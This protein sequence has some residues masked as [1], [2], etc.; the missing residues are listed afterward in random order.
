MS[1]RHS[2]QA[3]YRTF[4]S[5]APDSEGGTNDGIPRIPACFSRSA[6]ICSTDAVS[7]HSPWQPGHSR[8]L[9]VPRTTGFI[10]VRQRGQGSGLFSSTSFLSSFA[11]QCEQNLEPTKVI[12]KQAGQATVARRA[13][14]CSQRVASLEA[15]APHMGQFNVSADMI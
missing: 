12:P 9:V 11:P 3:K 2:G 13:P 10:S 15:E 14:Q 8:K 5:I 4:S 7:A 6:Q 1:F